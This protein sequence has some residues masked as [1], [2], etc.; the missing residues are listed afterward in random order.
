MKVLVA[1]KRVVDYN[2]KIRVKADGSVWQKGGQDTPM[3]EAC[4]R[5]KIEPRVGY[6]Q[7]R[8]TWA[9]HSVM[10]GMPLLL[11]ARSLGHKDTKQVER[12]YGH[13]APSY[14]VDQIRATAPR[15]GV[16]DDVTVIPMK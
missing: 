16:E 3:R 15:Y 10:N 11:V 2:V 14:I 6:H 1:V 8:H 7:L 13:L 4:A 5:A 12:T 9:S